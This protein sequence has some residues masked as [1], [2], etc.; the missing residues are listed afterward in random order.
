MDTKSFTQIIMNPV[1]QR[2][3][4]YLLIHEK[5]TPGEIQAE[6]PDVSTA[7]LYRHIKKLYDGNCI[8]VVEEKR[9]RGTIEKTYALEQ[10]PFD[11]EPTMQ[12][13]SSMFYT[14]LLSLQTSFLQYFEKE[15]VDPQKDMLSLQTS[16]L[17]LTD[18]EF[19]EFLQKLG[20]A[21]TGVINNGPGQGRKARR[22]TFISSPSEE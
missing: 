1:R 5:G 20:E 16:T 4:Q 10:S 7:S 22:I 21:F 18:E 19:M 6:L 17:M 8:K 3:V 2:I 15:D 9:V 14:M 12:D 13:M 11:A